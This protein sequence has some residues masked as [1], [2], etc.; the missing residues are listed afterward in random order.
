MTGVVVVRGNVV[1][2]DVPVVRITPR[3]DNMPVHFGN[4]VDA[5]A[6]TKFLFSGVAPNSTI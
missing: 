6:R 2:W 3:P 1:N 5:T 4:G